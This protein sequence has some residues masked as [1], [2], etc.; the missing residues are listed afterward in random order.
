MG[1]RIVP[2]SLRQDERWMGE[3]RQDQLENSSHFQQK[4]RI[5]AQSPTEFEPLWPPIAEH[6]KKSSSLGRI[7]DQHHSKYRGFGDEL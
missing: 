3:L 4:R 2:Q 5:W 6:L 7:V 1:I